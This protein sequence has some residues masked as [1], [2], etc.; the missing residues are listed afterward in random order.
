M[1]QEV[2]VRIQTEDGGQG[3]KLSYGRSDGPLGLL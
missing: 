3:L 2:V 1:G